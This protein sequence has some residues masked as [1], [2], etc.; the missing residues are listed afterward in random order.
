MNIVSYRL[1]I[2]STDKKSMSGSVEE[3][4]QNTKH[5]QS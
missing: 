3:T 1:R 4:Q 2:A 5:A